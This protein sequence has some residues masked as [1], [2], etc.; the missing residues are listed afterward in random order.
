MER[1]RITID[2]AGFSTLDQFYDEME[3]LLTVAPG[4][5]IGHNFDALRDLLRGGFGVQ[6]VGQ[7]IDFLWKNAAKSR[8]D[9]G[10]AATACY[11]QAVLQRC[12]PANRERAAQRLAQAQRG[13]GPTL[14]AMIT[15]LI[16]AKD[17]RYDHT[18]RLEDAA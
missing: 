13:E 6:Q 11:W 17:D 2:G 5:R 18:L 1:L 10:Y 3:R 7:G 9:F 4:G 16:L 12:H 8:Q 14:F 15:E